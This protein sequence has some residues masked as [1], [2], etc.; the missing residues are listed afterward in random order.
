MRRVNLLSFDTDE[1]LAWRAREGDREAERTLIL[2][3]YP[4]V[5]TLADRLLRNV[6]SARDATQEAFF[7][8]FSRIHQYDGDHRFS[9]WVFRILV[10]LIRDQRR[11]G[12]KV[13]TAELK[14]DDWPSHEPIPVD[15]VIHE[16]S[17]TRVKSHV[18]RLP[19]DMRVALLLHFQEG[20][21]GRE[22]AYALGITYDAARLKISRAVAKLRQWMGGE[23]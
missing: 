4:G 20:L 10:N 19:E 21:T 23:A 17:C 14:P 8:A 22:V 13:I 1:D 16:E 6:E 11:R 5:Y 12:N 3:L 18:E 9:A 7:R 15:A 2:R